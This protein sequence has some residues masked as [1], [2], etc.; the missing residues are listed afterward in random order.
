M[1][2]MYI[3]K[4]KCFLWNI[5][6]L[7]LQGFLFCCFLLHTLM[8]STQLYISINIKDFHVSR[9]FVIL[10][11]FCIMLIV[12][13]SLHANNYLLLY[14]QKNYIFCS[15]KIRKPEWPLTSCKDFKT[16]HLNI[17]ENCYLSL[18]MCLRNAYGVFH[19]RCFCHSLAS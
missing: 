9:L 13:P 5:G 15:N 12:N 10:L 4:K 3:L 14:M 8:I 18:Q 11:S 19:C 1:F 16:W 2:L 6:P 7:R 17:F